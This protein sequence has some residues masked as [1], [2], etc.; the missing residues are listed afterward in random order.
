MRP[1][2]AQFAHLR[3]PDLLRRL[4]SSDVDMARDM[5]GFVDDAEPVEAVKR[6]K[7]KTTL[8]SIAK[9]AAKAGLV[10]VRVEFDPDGRISGVVT[11]KPA[12]ANTELDEATPEDRSRWN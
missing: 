7:R 10:I 5:A 12:D 2:P 3:D 4:M 1:L 11:G 9:Q 6:R 8:A